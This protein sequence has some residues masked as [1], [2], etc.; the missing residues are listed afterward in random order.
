MSEIAQ[1]VCHPCKSSIIRKIHTPQK[2]ASPE[3]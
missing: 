3:S 1:G 2:N